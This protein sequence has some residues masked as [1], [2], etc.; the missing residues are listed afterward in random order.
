MVWCHDRF[1]S[2]NPLEKLVS[3]MIAFDLLIASKTLQLIKRVE[4]P[5]R[6]MGSRFWVYQWRFEY[7]MGWWEH[8]TTPWVKKYVKPGMTIVNIGAHIGSCSNIFSMLVEP[9]PR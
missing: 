3:K 8:E 9:S 5:K 4:F 1:N 6:S 7:L 2:G